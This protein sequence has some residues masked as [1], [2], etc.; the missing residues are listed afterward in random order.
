MAVAAQL[1][2]AYAI[3]SAALL[4][5]ANSAVPTQNDICGTIAPALN[6]N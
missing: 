1:Q 4:E 6:A 5:L 3:I 2:A